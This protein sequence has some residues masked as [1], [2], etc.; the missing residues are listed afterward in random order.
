MTIEG[1]QIR[2]S[3]VAVEA[4]N[5]IA[6]VYGCSIP[7]VLREE[8]GGKVSLV[9]ECYVQVSRRDLRSKQNLHSLSGDDVACLLN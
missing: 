3:P 6:V 9:G 5:I 7:V 2:L 4:G 1:G 8:D